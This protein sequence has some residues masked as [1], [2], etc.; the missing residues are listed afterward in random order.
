MKK[1]PVVLSL[2]AI[3]LLSSGGIVAVNADGNYHRGPPPGHNSQTLSLSLAGLV[4]SAGSQHYIIDQHG[5]PIAATFG[6]TLA[7]Y[8]F[9]PSQPINLD[10]HLNAFV[11]GLTANGY[12]NFDL[13][14]TLAGS[15]DIVDISGNAQI[16]GM[17]AAE[18]LPHYD[19][20]STGT[21]GS[22]DTSA[23]PA[24]FVGA[25]TIT[26]TTMSYSM[27]RYHDYS[28]S[29]YSQSTTLHGVPML[30]ESAYMNPFGAPIVFGTA[31]SFSTLLV[32]TTYKH[33]MIDWN[34]VVVSGMLGGTLGTTPVSGA[35]TE[36]SQEHENLVT[37]NA[38]DRGTMSFSQVTNMSSGAA[39]SSLDVSGNY[40]GTSSTPTSP[41]LDCSSSILGAPSSVLGFSVCTEYGFQSNGSF[42]LS[43]HAGDQ[44]EHYED[45][46]LVRGTYSTTWGIPAFSFGIPNSGLYSEGSSSVTAIVTTTA[47]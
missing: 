34:N 2:L 47:S 16:V 27:Q 33:A 5:S 35:F 29:D 26:V 22:G 43:S 18:C 6:G 15:S 11:S 42:H 25:S 40:H 20:S 1:L 37:G 41:A 12:A 21:C 39:I 10:Y 28:R 14:G 32:I 17:V 4:V 13:R 36:I 38:M 8:A 9:D 3:L 46:T 31:D 24:F 30:F 7:N 19:V 44:H 45:A 23:V